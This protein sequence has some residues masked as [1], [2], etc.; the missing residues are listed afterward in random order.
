MLDKTPASTDVREG[1][2]RSLGDILKVAPT[3][4]AET[5]IRMLRVTGFLPPA[6][7]PEEEQERRRQRPPPRAAPRPPGVSC[8]GGVAQLSE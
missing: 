6:A 5:V 7:E 2:D 1:R 4:V 8:L 3:D